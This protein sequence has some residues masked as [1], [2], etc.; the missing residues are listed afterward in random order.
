MSVAL[1]SRGLAEPSAAPPRPA[2]RLL[3]RACACGGSA[4]LSGRCGSCESAGR[5]GEDLLQAKFA[6]SSPG[7]PFELEADRAAEAVMRGGPPPRIT[8]LGEGRD[9][10]QRTAERLQREAAEETAEEDE[11]EILAKA[12]GAASAPG[13]AFAAQLHGTGGGVPLPATSRSFFERGFGRDLGHVRVHHGSAA[14]TLAR[15]INARAFT[16]GAD[17][18]FGAGQYDASSTEG[19]RLLA[20]ELAHTVQQDDGTLRRKALDAPLPANLPPLVR[21]PMDGPANPNEVAAER[22]ASAPEAAAGSAVPA[23]DG[24]APSDGTADVPAALA[25]DIL[26]PRGGAPLPQHVRE[27]AEGRLGSDFGHVRVHTGIRAAALAEWLDARA[28]TWGEHVWL[29]E[30]EHQGDMRLMLHELTHVRQQAPRARRRI[31]ATKLW[32]YALPQLGPGSL[33]PGERLHDLVLPWLKAKEGNLYTEVPIP[34]GANSDK[35]NT[36]RADLVKTSTGN[37]FGVQFKGTEPAYRNIYG[38]NAKSRKKGTTL[39]G[40]EVSETAHRKTAAPVGNT[41]KAGTTACAGS[42]LPDGKGIC[43][44]DGA[45]PEVM[46]GDLKPNSAAEVL[47]GGSQLDNYITK[48]NAL[49]GKVDT[50]ATA[51]PTL[52]HPAGKSWGGSARRLKAG[53]ISVPDFFATPTAAT[54]K[55]VEAALYVN[56]DMTGVRDDTVIRLAKEGDGFITWELV[57]VSGFGTGA[58]AAPAAPATGGITSVKTDLAPVKDELKKEPENRIGKLR[59]AGRRRLARKPERA[60]K[61]DATDPFNLGDWQRAH[62]TPWRSKA[63]K[64]TG[65]AGPVARTSPTA[66]AEARMRAEALRQIRERTE[67]ASLRKPA[68]GTAA[69]TR[70]LDI[71]QHWVDKG[72]VY[73]QLRRFLG[74]SYIKLARAYDT[75]KTRIEA[76][77]D[78][79]RTRMRRASG[80]AGGIKGAV[81]AALRGIAGSLLGLFVRDVGHR[82]MAAIKKGA[83]V[84]IGTLFGEEAAAIDEQLKAIEQAEEDFKAFIAEALEAKFKAQMEALDARIREIES[85]AGTLKAVG[86]VVNIV[87]WAYRIAQCAAPPALGCLL[88][89]VGSAIA[90]AILAAIVAS[91]WFQREIAYPLIA[92]LG[93]VKALPGLIAKGIADLIRGLLPE[94]IKPL[95]AEVDMGDLASKPDDIDCDADSGNT[96]NSLT[97]EQKRLAELLKAYDPDHVDALLRALKHLGLIKDPPDAAD[98]LSMAGIDKLEKLLDTYTRQQLEELITKAPQR[99]F[100]E[101]GLDQAAPDLEKVAKEQGIETGPAGGTA[102]AADAGQDAAPPPTPEALVAEGRKIAERLAKLTTLPPVG[103]SRWAPPADLKVGDT[104]T[105]FRVRRVSHTLVIAGFQKITYQSINEA[106]GNGVVT[107]HGGTHYFTADGTFVETEVEQLDVAFTR[108]K[109]AAK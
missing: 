42:G 10:A 65:G 104:V 43:R 94:K 63:E 27:I 47:L 82:L 26:T 55:H 46:I 62:Y 19:R 103:E 71:V 60:P 38:G 83:T 108:T 74:T 96:Y 21:L 61:L 56:G 66:E 29:G 76:K 109:K 53:E 4:G 69:R 7:D 32:Y 97:P 2:P 39:N 92:T 24:A 67:M 57:P 22:A 45:P 16:H 13:P 91:C 75:L 51:N 35:G 15:D 102:P 34:E 68:E 9:D 84:L 48:V 52:I 85:I 93:P 98:K 101:G 107:I 31:Q 90:E 11:E 70:E 72:L 89:L 95:M 54:G 28:F 23:D 58:A 88:G 17:I 86:D 40:V 105:V 41:T 12:A 87:K 100:R 33:G 37:L 78:A 77:V 44:M 3:Q 20:H 106:A 49:I 73:G 14:A 80:G 81:L 64:A 36:G 8:A 6:V 1:A 5:F 30:G 25:P 18:Y 79:A 99:P 59:R 50:F